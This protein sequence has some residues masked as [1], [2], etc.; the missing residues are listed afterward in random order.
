MLVVRQRRGQARI[1]LIS[2]VDVIFLLLLF[3]LLTTK[4]SDMEL[5]ELNASKAKTGASDNAKGPTKLIVSLTHESAYVNDVPVP[6]A[7]LSDTVKPY[8][9]TYGVVIKSGETATLQQMV[10]AI[11]AVK[12]AGGNEITLEGLE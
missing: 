7:K 2:L 6:Y 3:F 1:V 11:D 4:F 5:I 12:V 9:P 10:M 8:L